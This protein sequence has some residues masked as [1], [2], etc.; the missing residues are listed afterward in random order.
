MLSEENNTNDI[1]M[2]LNI[3]FTAYLCL[4]L[5]IIVIVL[6]KYFFSSEELFEFIEKS[7]KSSLKL[8]SDEND[9]LKLLTELNTK[10]N[11]DH[12]DNSKYY[13]EVGYTK[14]YGKKKDKQSSDINEKHIKKNIEKKNK[15]KIFIKKTKKVFFSNNI[16]YENEKENENK[17]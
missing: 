7:K 3:P 15:N 16:I 14:I 4:I 17:H 2:D 10:I 12:L 9:K 5:I 1:I 11:R 13:N 8:F 6:C